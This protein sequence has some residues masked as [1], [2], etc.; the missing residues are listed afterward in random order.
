[1]K[2]YSLSYD[3]TSTGNNQKYAYEQSLKIDFHKQ[4]FFKLPA[5]KLKFTLPRR[6]RILRKDIEDL[7]IPEEK[8][9]IIFDKVSWSD[10]VLVFKSTNKDKI[11]SY[12]DDA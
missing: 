8:L 10:K 2:I 9:S 1:L 11:I 3:L 12:I 5:V 7:N 6:K 4:N